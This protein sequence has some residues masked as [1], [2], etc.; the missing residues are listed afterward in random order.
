ML[1][2]FSL[3]KGKYHANHIQTNPD[4]IIY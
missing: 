4:A 3:H 1:L 2:T